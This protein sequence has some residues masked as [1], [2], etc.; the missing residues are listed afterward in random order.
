[1]FVGGAETKQAA[2]VVQYHGVGADVS[3]KTG[4]ADLANEGYKKNAIVYRCINEIANGI[5]QTPMSVYSDDQ[6]L[7]AHPLISLLR[8]PAPTTGYAEFFQSMVS[9][10]LLSGNAFIVRSGPDAGEPQELYLLRPD[11]MRIKP[12]KHL[13]YAYEYVVDGKVAER[14]L[15]DPETG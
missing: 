6:E 1:M 2:P 4:Y 9:Q 5:A 8:S 15:V 7:E 11:R 12:G 3:Y 13:P 10:L 14:Y